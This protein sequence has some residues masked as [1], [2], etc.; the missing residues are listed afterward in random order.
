MTKH[1]SDVMKGD[2]VFKNCVYFFR[3]L[4]KRA[5]NDRQMTSLHMQEGTKQNMNK[6][7]AVIAKKQDSSIPPAQTHRPA[8][9]FENPKKYRNLKRQVFHMFARKLLKNIKKMEAP[10]A[11]QASQDE[12]AIRREYVCSILK[13]FTESFQAF[14][15]QPGCA[16]ELKKFIAE[17][18]EILFQVMCRAGE[19]QD[20]AVRI[21]AQL[22][23][24]L[25]LQQVLDLGVPFREDLE[26]LY[27]KLLLKPLELLD[28]KLTK[29]AQ[30]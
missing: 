4:R 17:E 1:F 14:S 24:S 5:I 20:I 11:G 10:V 30:N 18:K 23:F 12:L 6:L 27:V 29:G 22:F 25:F 3:V 13:A 8:S 15:R 21:M 19:L 2:E 7:F 9:E 16:S 26:V 28:D